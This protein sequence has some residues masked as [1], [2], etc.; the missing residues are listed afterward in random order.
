MAAAVFDALQAPNQPAG[1]GPGNAS[2]EPRWH[3]SRQTG[4]SFQ[5]EQT[6][7][8]QYADVGSGP[9]PGPGMY[10]R[11]GPDVVQHR[12]RHGTKDLQ[13]PRRRRCR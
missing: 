3:H 12:R 8:T 11:M 13:E 5:L 4:G 2:P 10:P 9:G 7:R 6:A 1:W